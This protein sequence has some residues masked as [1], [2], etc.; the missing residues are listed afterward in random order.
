M[1]CYSKAYGAPLGRGT[2]K[3]HPNDFRVTELYDF[4]PSG[5]GEHLLLWVEKTGANTGWVGNQLATHFKLRHFDVSYCG[6]KDRHAVTGQWFSCWLPGVKEIP[7]LGSV[8]I[9]GVDFQKAVW[10]HRKLRRGDHQGNRFE[11]KLR[12]LTI[13]STA[14]LDARLKLISEQGFPNYFGPQRFGIDNQNLVKAIDLISDPEAQSRRKLDRKQKDIYMSALRSW[15]FNLSLE[16]LVKVDDWAD[17][18]EIWVYGL[19]P[20]RDIKIPVVAE[21]H[22]A[23]A[24]F[25]EKIGIK[26]HQRAKRVRP[27]QMMWEFAENEMT[28]R[29][30]LPVGA[31]ATTLLAE[32]LDLEDAQMKTGE[33]H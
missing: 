2:I 20:H 30:D 9:E 6:K 16:E 15:L 14:D 10:H 18:G 24:A 22:L 3:T 19:S 5:S 25:I 27:K 32:I 8:Q 29:F 21:T 4:E 28:L 12:E 13:S 17:E 31:Y 1:N 23:A 11:L 7:D 33:P 26:A